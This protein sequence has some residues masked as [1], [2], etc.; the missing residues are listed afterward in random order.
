M[1]RN[2][3]KTAPDKISK[4]IL[5]SVIVEDFLPPP[6]KLVRKEE[7]LKITISL[8]KSSVG[9]FKEKA[10]KIGIPYQT[11]IKTVLDKYSSHYQNLK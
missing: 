3:F 8:S 2:N 9:F 5:S 6:E 1:N 7:N 4:A 11:I 10:K